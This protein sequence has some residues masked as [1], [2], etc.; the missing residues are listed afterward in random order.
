MQ[1]QFSFLISSTVLLCAGFLFVFNFCRL[2]ANGFAKLND[3]QTGSRKS[4]DKQRMIVEGAKKN[5]SE[6]TEYDLT[7]GYYVLTYKDGVNTG[8]RVFPGGDLD[9]KIGV[10]TD[11]IVRSLRYAGIVDLQEAV[12]KDI[13]AAMSDYPISR[14][15]KKKADPNI[16]HRRVMNLEV[17]FGKYWQSPGNNDFQPGDIVVWDMN[18]DG[19]SDH[20]GIVSDGT[21]E[22]RHTVIHNHPDP[23]H[24]AD[25]DKLYKWKI[26]GHYRIKDN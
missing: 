24:I 5:L 12:N 2:D 3:N 23:G 18:E 16:D 15:G 25:E 8:S 19:A 26:T 10:C 11:V 20:T 14:W 6:G 22:G 1:R 7:M 17:W 13:K 9:P 21:A 4:D